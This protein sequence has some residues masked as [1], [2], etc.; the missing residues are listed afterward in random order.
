M[1]EDNSIK[2]SSVN[3]SAHHIYYDYELN[4]PWSKYFNIDEKMAVEFSVDISEVPRSIALIPLL[5]N[6][7]PV[8]WLCDAKVYLPAIDKTFYDS[9]SEFKTGYIEMHRML[10]FKGELIPDSIEDNSSYGGDGCL[11]LFSGG[12]DAFNTL[13]SHMEEKP[14]LVTLWGSDVR[15]DDGEGWEKVLRHVN[16]TCHEFDLNSVTVKTNFRTIISE[17]ELDQLVTASG[18][19]WWHGFQHGLGILSHT[20]PIAYALKK[21]CVYIASSFTIAEK[22]ISCASDPSIDNFIRFGST[23]VVHDGYEFN[24]QMKLSNISAYVRQHN[25][26]IRLH[27]CWISKGGDN[28]CR[29]EK[30]VRTIM[31]L[32]ANGDNPQEYGFRYDSFADVCRYFRSNGSFVKKNHR[33]LYIQQAMRETYSL[34]DVEPDLRWFYKADLARFN[35]NPIYRR[36]VKKLKR[37]LIARKK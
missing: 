26:P 6:I 4:G 28:C 34:H 17:G 30:C 5:G 13:F 7:L 15:L 21:A 18:D 3:I 8:A 2:I 16:T 10:E 32:Y 35:L 27:V 11:T 1:K 14:T 25:K 22:G 23:Q 24:R 33:Y 31:G 37:L 36:I 12:V 29:C 19:G 20:A 9:I